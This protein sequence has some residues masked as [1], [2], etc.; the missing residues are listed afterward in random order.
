MED[1]SAIQAR[2]H[3][4]VWQRHARTHYAKQTSFNE[5]I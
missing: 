5:A 4:A 3:M 1:G 2:D